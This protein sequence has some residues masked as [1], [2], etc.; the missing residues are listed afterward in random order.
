MP[1]EQPIG[2]DPNALTDVHQGFTQ[3]ASATPPAGG[4]MFAP[5]R[6]EVLGT[7]GRGGMGVVYKARDTAL[8]RLVALKVLPATLL[9]EP[10]RSERFEREVRAAAQLSHPNLVPVL[11]V[12]LHEGLPCY[13]MPFVEGGTLAQRLEDYR[14]PR[15]AVALLEKVARGVQAAHAR[16]IVHRDLKPGNILLDGRG[17]PLVADFGL[18]RFAD[19]SVELTRT[20]QQIGTPA[21]M[22]P[23]QA[24]GHNDRVKPPS[25]VWALGVILY[26]LLAG[27]R[28]F[29]GQSNQAVI[30]QILTTQPPRPRQL[31]H[32]V[33]RDL[34]AVVL[35]C[36]EK[37]PS[38]RYSTAGELAADLGR[39]LRGEAVHATGMGRWGRA[40]KLLIRRPVLAGLGLAAALLLLFVLAGPELR[41]L[42]PRPRPAATGPL[43]FGG[44]QGQLPQR[45]LCGAGQRQWQ[46]GGVLCLKPDPRGTGLLELVARVPW[47][48]YRF[49][50]EVRHL[51]AQQGEVGIYVNHREQP[52]GGRPEHWFASLTFAEQSRVPAV[53]AGP[54]ALAVASLQM[55]RYRPP[56]G[57]AGSAMAAT[58]NPA[59][60]F[61][62]APGRWR[63]LILEVT[64]ETAR[65]YW[66]REQTPFCQ[67]IR[68][69][70]MKDALGVLALMKPPVG[71]PPRPLPAQGGLGL[72]CAGGNALFK[73]LVVEPLR[74]NP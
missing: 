51:D 56:A 61:R 59:K 32:A 53:A 73:N 70:G 8:G 74:E 66:E 68:A 25:D 21:Y 37:E 39:W 7:V 11:D 71:R 64:P 31:S 27:Q 65:A 44:D 17:D 43:R 52:Q 45:W 29:N 6:L 40:R 33:P 28:P 54:P 36:L 18:A 9:D 34:E 30:Q 69:T 26:Q 19:S 35:K 1:T 38:R 62:A 2:G 42:P 16:D 67:L 22:S 4:A 60:H 72:C 23:E 46:A 15:A 58:T 63:K 20:G 48:R 12:G 57:D 14:E 24:A 3:P 5:G 13:A 55:Q 49:S 41:T 47:E 50:A 10:G